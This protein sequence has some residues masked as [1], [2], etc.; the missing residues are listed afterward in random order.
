MGCFLPIVLN[1]MRA[2]TMRKTRMRRASIL[3]TTA[4][5]N[6]WRIGEYLEKERRRMEED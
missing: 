3:V 5:M 4:C 6:T 2:M 1:R